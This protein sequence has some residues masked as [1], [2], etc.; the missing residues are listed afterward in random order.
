M[1]KC[2]PELIIVMYIGLL[3]TLESSLS[4][5]KSNLKSYPHFDLS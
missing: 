5:N 1:P 2:D 3:R 4:C